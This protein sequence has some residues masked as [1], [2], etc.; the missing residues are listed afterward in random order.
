MPSVNRVAGCLQNLSYAAPVI[1]ALYQEV[2]TLS[3]DIPSRDKGL[4]TFKKNIS[5]K[6]FLNL[7]EV[8][9]K[10]VSNQTR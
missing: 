10:S 5:S 4:L 2:Q 1:N 3:Q 6:L 8:E 9:L 7:S